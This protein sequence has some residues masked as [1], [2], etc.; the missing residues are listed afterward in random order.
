MASLLVRTACVV[1]LVV[2][3]ATGSAAPGGA[4]GPG[5][6]RRADARR[7][8]IAALDARL[9][10]LVEKAGEDPRIG[11]VDA[12][13]ALARADEFAST[14][15]TRVAE[16]AEYLADDDAPRKLKERVRDALTSIPHRSLDPDLA[17]SEGRNRRVAYCRDRLLPLLARPG[18]V[19]LVTRTLT[20]AI[21]E[22]FWR[23]TDA[24][25]QQYD[26]QVEATWKKAADAYRRGMVAR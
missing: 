23:F 14:R 7:A 3:A 18:D 26:P 13:L 19:A 17:P 25:I 5:A 20:A 8:R 1:G 10:A 12:Y 16:L 9:T 21:L 22:S 24:A 15:R 11:R 6:G 2:L 4:D